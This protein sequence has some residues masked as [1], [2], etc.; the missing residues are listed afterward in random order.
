MILT[1]TKFV[2][3]KINYFLW[4]NF[5]INLYILTIWK[6]SWTGC[7]QSFQAYFMAFSFH[8]QSLVFK[9]CKEPFS[10]HK[11][12]IRQ[13]ITKKLKGSHEV[14]Q[15]SSNNKHWLTFKTFS[16][17]TVVFDALAITFRILMEALMSPIVLLLESDV[18]LLSCSNITV[19]L[20]SVLA[21][22]PCR[23]S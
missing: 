7:F 18:K 9:L 14:L 23:K 21:P 16:L 22:S 13:V 17:I 11:G 12:R 1:F 2:L 8:W 6:F 4:L 20:V 19:A 15:Y 10:I 5:F 3:L